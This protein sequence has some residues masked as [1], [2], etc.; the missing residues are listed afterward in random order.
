VGGRD[1]H[2]ALRESERRFREMID[3]LPVAIYTTDA[4]GRLTHFNEAAVRLSGR[5]PELGSDRWCVSW[6][7]FHPDGRPMPHD[8]CPMA[9]ALKEGRPVREAEIIVERPDG[10]RIWCAPYPTPLFDAEGRRDR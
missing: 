3:V 4:A 2:E 10:K 1:S 6:K 8:E 7:L 9:V 5:V